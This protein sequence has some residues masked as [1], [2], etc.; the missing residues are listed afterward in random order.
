MTS[1]EFLFPVPANRLDPMNKAIAIVGPSGSGKTE[2]I[3]R[4]LG[5]FGRQGLKVAVLKHT[6]HRDP[7]DQGKDTWRFRQ[8]GARAV[9]LAGP[10]LLQVTRT[11]PEEP[12]LVAALAELAPG[13]DLILVEGY[14][15]GPLPKIAVLNPDSKEP[16]PSYSGVIATVSQNPADLAGPVFQPGEVAA[17]GAFIWAYLGLPESAAS[18]PRLSRPEKNCSH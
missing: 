14:K 2:L 12:Q 17:I 11:Y 8:A 9:A 13:V 16:P 5:W 1:T 18:G 10:G 7:G 3:C 6:H 4:L 15:Y